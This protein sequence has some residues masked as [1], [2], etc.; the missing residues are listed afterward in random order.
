[1][2]STSNTEHSL[3]ARISGALPT[4]NPHTLFI[5]SLEQLGEECIKSSERKSE[6]REAEVNVQG[7]TAAEA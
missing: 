4:G 2:H 5:S 1:M 7:H 3:C 6:P